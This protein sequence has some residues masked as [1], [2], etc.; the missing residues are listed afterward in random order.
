[1]TYG[2]YRQRSNE[3]GRLAAQ[4]KLDVVALVVLWVVKETIN[5]AFVCSSFVQ[6]R[7]LVFSDLV[8]LV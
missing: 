5:V 3:F 7:L 6:V 4:G 8:W 2:E 1:M